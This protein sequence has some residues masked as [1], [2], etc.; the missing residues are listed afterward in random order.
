MAE[1]RITDIYVDY[2]QKSRVFLLPALGVKK[3]TGVTPINTYLEW[4]DKVKVSD[5]KLVCLYHLRTDDEFI[6]FERKY[7]HG[8][9]LFD[10]YYEV[11]DG[12]KA[13]YIFDFNQHYSE[14]FDHVLNGRYSKLSKKLKEKIRDS[15]GIAS[16]NYRYVKTYL[17][18]NIYYQTYSEI[19]CPDKQDVPDMV[20]LLE[21]VG[22]LCSKPDLSR[23]RLKMSVKSLKL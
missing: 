8:N 15:Y 2:F 5:K 6:E 10:D 22:E 13:I 3:G 7:L 1:K 23:E 18:P 20:K 16:G 14:D 4:E 12:K 9:L 21:E 17:Y 19:L 11:E